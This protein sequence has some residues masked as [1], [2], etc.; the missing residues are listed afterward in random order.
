VVHPEPQLLLAEDF[1]VPDMLEF[2]EGVVV[3]VEIATVTNDD[4]GFGEWELD[5]TVT[6]DDLFYS[7]AVSVSDTFEAV[8][9][10]LNYSYGAYKISPRSETDLE[11]HVPYVAPCP[12]DLCVDDLIAGQLVITEIMA[13]PKT[14]ADDYC[15]WIEIYNAS[16]QSV[17]LFDLVIGDDDSASSWGEVKD[18]TIVAAG[19]YAV[20]A[21]S[22]AANWSSQCPEL[23]AAFTPDGHYGGA[24]G[25]SNDGDP[26]TLQTPAG[27]II[28]AIP[29]YGTKD[30]CQLTSGTPDATTNDTATNWCVPMAVVATDSLVTTDIDYGTPGAANT[31]C[32]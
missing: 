27:V 1:E 28:D 11:G 3:R 8:Q 24:L 12:A 23:L 18:E 15:E 25:L 31:T 30:S 9:G 17:D 26:L 6:V 19:D 16:G 10:P 4:L 29:S 21:K 20:V 14:G 32:M 7:P 22:T 2:F 5:G 13:D